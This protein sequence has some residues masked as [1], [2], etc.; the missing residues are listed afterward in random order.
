MESP[1]HEPDRVVSAADLA[2]RFAEFAR[3]ARGSAI[4]NRNKGD[5]F[6]EKLANTRA[7]V[8]VQAAELIRAMPLPQAAATMMERAGR[9]HVRTPPL[10][11]FDD[12]GTRYIAARAWQFCALEINPELEHAAPQWT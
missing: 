7:E 11:G 2:D 5:Q 9:L 12:A 3:A 10:M 8:Y 4:K 1:A 6:G